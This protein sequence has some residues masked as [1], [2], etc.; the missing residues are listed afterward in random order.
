MAF[1][2]SGNLLKCWEILRGLG[3]SSYNLRDVEL[4]NSNHLTLQS[5]LHFVVAYKVIAFH[6]P[7]PK[8]NQSGYEPLNLENGWFLNSYNFDATDVSF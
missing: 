1:R 4:S 6:P 7:H 5:V 3:T 8:L 2:L